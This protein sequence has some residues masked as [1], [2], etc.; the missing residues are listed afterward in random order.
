MPEGHEQE[1]GTCSRK[2]QIVSLSQTNCAPT[3]Q[4]SFNVK[5]TF[6]FRR[7]QRIFWKHELRVEWGTLLGFSSKAGNLQPSYILITRSFPCCVHLATK[8]W[9]LKN[10]R[11]M[12]LTRQRLEAKR[13][14]MTIQRVYAGSNFFVVT[15]EMTED[16]PIR[17][18]R[19]LI[20]FSVW[21]E[22]RPRFLSRMKL[23]V[24]FQHTQEK[25]P[26][27]KLTFQCIESSLSER[28]NDTTFNRSVWSELQ[29]GIQSAGLEEHP[30]YF[31][32]STP[33]GKYPVIFLM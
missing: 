10:H 9:H 26:T 7:T 18:G 17:K 15:Q 24:L 21:W 27:Q 1:G 6:W 29:F 5:V 25:T 20:F 31:F 8:R 30:Q 33:Y 3:S 2:K 14:L 13:W 11:S 4:D 32:H 12:V 19:P 22:T 23:G 28:T 16:L